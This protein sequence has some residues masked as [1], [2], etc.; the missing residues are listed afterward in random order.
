MKDIRTTQNYFEISKLELFGLRIKTE[1]P[2]KI[3]LK[4]IPKDIAIGEVKA[5]LMKLGF[6]VHSVGHIKISKGNSIF[7]SIL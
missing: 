3:I 5:E 2:H 4:G 6:S 7:R 1:R